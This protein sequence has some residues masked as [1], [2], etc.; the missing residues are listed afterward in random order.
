M[1][2]FGLIPVIQVFI[3]LIIV[4][5]SFGQSDMKSLLILAEENYPLI[6][7]KQAEAEAA[8]VNVALEK[9]RLLPSLD[10]A[11]QAN[12]STYNNITGM[13]YPGMLL[14]ISGPPTTENYNNLVPGS[15]V[16][17]LLKWSPVTF[18]QRTAAVEYNR[19]L[20]EKQLAGIE[21]EVL[22]LKFRVAFLYLEMASTKELLEVFRNNIERNEFNLNQVSSLVGA[23]LRPGVDSLRFKSELSK[24]RTELYKLKNLLETQKQ[25]LKELLVSETF[26]DIEM[27]GFFTENLPVEPGTLEDAAD[28]P[29]LKM[30][31]LE[32]EANQARLV[33]INRSWTPKLEFWGTTYA[34]GSGIAFD[35]TISKADGWS[36][37][38]YNYGVGLQLVFPILDLTNVKLRSNRHEAVI[39]SVENYFRQTQITLN[40]EESIAM[41]DLRTSLLIAAEVPFEFEASQAAFNAIQTRY[42]SGLIDYSDLI[43]AQY[44]L[45]HAEAGLKNAFVSSWKSLLKLAVIQGD[46]NIF[47]NQIQN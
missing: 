45:L 19:K 27:H 21:N 17:L 6:A 7:A 36:F 26:Q 10:A 22:R 42:S 2:R 41:S 40:K 18:G 16:S 39:R 14:P 29:V 1:K 13:S 5:F 20:Y 43:Q 46:V 44:D 31:R 11:Y 35:G 32:L 8:Q 34:R 23:G 37:S 25:E 47:L 15:A 24:A 9:N 38:R 12:Y 3:S 4:E 28:N 33:Q 30:A